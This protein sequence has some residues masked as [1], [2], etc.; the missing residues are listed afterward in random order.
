[1]PFG[2]P[3]L[4]TGAM[5]GQVQLHHVTSNWA[6]GQTLHCYRC[7]R[8]RVKDI[9]VDPCSP[10]LFWSVSEDSTCRQYDVRENHSC[11]RLG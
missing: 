1:M 4:V 10:H 11:S 3:H 2:D 9:V 8:G 7:H 5:D 6:S